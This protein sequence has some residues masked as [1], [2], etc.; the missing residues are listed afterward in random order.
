MLGSNASEALFMARRKTNQKL[1]LYATAS[2]GELNGWSDVRRL[3]SEVGVNL[4]HQV[5]SP[6]E[7]VCQAL[8]PGIL[9]YRSN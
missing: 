1:Q 3:C 6:E 4:A 8:E 7:S 9:Q 5:L 2:A